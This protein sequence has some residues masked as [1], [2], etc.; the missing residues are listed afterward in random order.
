MKNSM[1]E[2]WYHIYLSR[3]HHQSFSVCF[4]FALCW[5]IQLHVQSLFCEQAHI[6]PLTL[7]SCVKI[8]GF[9][10]YIYTPTHL[11]YISG[12]S[13]LL[14]PAS[15]LTPPPPVMACSFHNGAS[16]GGPSLT[17]WSCLPLRSRILRQSWPAASIMV[18]S[19]PQWH[20]R[21][22]SECLGDGHRTAPS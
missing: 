21:P 4:F 14:L 7:S 9:G 12:P 5:V 3:Q 20:W 11:V 16:K 18:P 22:R 6:H 8:V 1:K 17:T 19:L 2:C 15:P 13:Y 10:S